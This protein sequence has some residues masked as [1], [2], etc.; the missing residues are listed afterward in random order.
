[1]NC[2]VHQIHNGL[3]YIQFYNLKKYDDIITHCF[4]TRHGGVSTGECSSL[5]L[6]FNRNDSRENV[7]ENYKRLS[8][9]LGIDYKNMVFS[10]QVHEANVKVVGEQDRG[11]GIICESDIKGYDG[12]VTDR[13]GVVLV[14]FYAD[15]VPVYFFDPEKRVIAVS[16]S[17]WRGTVKEIGAVTV[18]KMAEV[19]GS[20]PA[21]IEAAIG[22]SI[23]KCC[24]ETGEEVYEEF[25][26]KLPWSR[27]LCTKKHGCKWHIDLQSV[28]CQS[29]V[30]SGLNINNICIS[31]LCTVCNHDMFFSHRA[32]KG[33]TGSL[34]AI[35]QIKEN[36]G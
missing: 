3:K 26:D 33:K 28:I 16:H 27:S 2:V 22:P 24:F 17:G 19:Y 18:R 1:M 8:Q 12:L 9:A 13:A 25:V 11:K 15:C 30:N 29:L 10:N 21:N 23:A 35:M 34:A 6:G 31:N 5:N 36:S 14:T 20:N 7:L 32:D 4:T